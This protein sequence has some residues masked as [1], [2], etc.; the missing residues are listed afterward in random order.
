MGLKKI[1]KRIVSLFL[2]IALVCSSFLT[3]AEDIVIISSGPTIESISNDNSRVT[4]NAKNAD[5]T[6][7]NLKYSFDNGNIWSFF[8]FQIVSKKTDFQVGVIQVKDINGNVTK[9]TQVITVDPVGNI[10]ITAPIFKT[11]VE[12]YIVTIDARDETKLHDEAFSFDGGVTWQASN[13]YDSNGVDKVWTLNQIIVRD[14]ANNKSGNKFDVCVPKTEE[15]PDINAP[16]EFTLNIVENRVDIVI[17]NKIEGAKYFYS[18]D[19]GQIW[20]TESFF[21][22][23]KTQTIPANKIMVL[24][25]ADKISYEL[26]DAYLECKKPIDVTGPNFTVKVKENDII[27]TQTDSDVL[28]ENPYSFDGGRTWVAG[29]MIT[30]SNDPVVFPINTF[31]MKN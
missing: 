1:S 2:V 24:N 14:A 11:K 18:F 6:T 23:S 19:G 8:N 30:V 22:A 15:Q 10:D 21:V 9:N 28:P 5:G 17:T 27:I 29:N 3:F 12:G 20:S 16:S 31:L 25:Q 7:S 13:I 26:Q 4:V